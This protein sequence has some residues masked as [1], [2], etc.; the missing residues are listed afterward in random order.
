MTAIGDIT[1]FILVG[2]KG[3]RLQATVPSVPKPLAPVSGKPF[4]AFV[5]A[6]LRNQGIRRCVLCTG[7]MAEQIE[8]AFGDGT[9]AGMSILYSRETEP[10][11]TAGALRL[12]ARYA[13]MDSPILVANGDTLSEFD[14]QRLYEF[15]RQQNALVTIAATRVLDAARFGTIQ[16]DQQGRVMSFVEKTGLSKPGLIN[17][18]VY[19]V[20]P[21]L[22][23]S[24]PDGYV[25]WES[26]ILPMLLKSRLY[27]QEHSGLFID[28][29]IPS[30]YQRAEEIS[31]S[32]Y[33]AAHGRTTP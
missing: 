25:S 30:E 14:L 8:E 6:Y 3:T 22:L 27:A 26:T 5:I 24:I 11:G 1:A 15:H 31:A 7:H 2:G 4:L 21:A 18:G 10:M 12:A 28:I 33:T 29:G 9:D 13:G 20:A 19:L 16:I 17:A 23:R 32:L